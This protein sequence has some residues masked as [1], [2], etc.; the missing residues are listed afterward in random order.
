MTSMIFMALAAGLASAL[1]FASII[2]GALISLALCYLAPLPLMVAA[3]GWGWLSAA[4]GGV[5]AGVGLAAIFGVHLAIVYTLAVAV[6]SVWLGH[7]ALLARPVADP[8]NP[9]APER[10]EWYPTGRPSSARCPSHQ[11]GSAMVR[12]NAMP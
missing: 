1:M 6:P 8:N 2:S 11:A 7:L 4:I 10:L 3:L 5:A 9:A 12:P